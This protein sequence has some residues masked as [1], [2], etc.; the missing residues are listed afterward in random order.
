MTVKF[1]DLFAGIGGIRIGVQQALDEIGVDHECVLSCEIDQK[2]RETYFE[3]FAE[4]PFPDIRELKKLPDHDILLAGFPCQPFSYAGKQQG[5]GDTRG[6]LFFEIE[7]LI[8]T[9]KPKLV[10]LENVR[11]LASHDKGRTLKTILKKLENLGYGVDFRI[12]NSANHG[13]PQN[14]MR[15][16][17]VAILGKS[18][19]ITINSDDKF[20]DTHQFLDAQPSLFDDGG[21]GPTVGDCL[22]SDVDESYRCSPKFTKA[23]KDYCNGDFKK[24]E[25]MRLI[26]SRNGNS[27]HSWELGLR[28]KC[29]KQEIA[30][31]DAIIA[32]RRKKVFG[33]EKDGKELSI[34]QI[35]TFFD[36]PNLADL[37]AGLVKKGYLRKNG[38]LYNP[39]IG[40]FSFEVFKFLNPA[41]VSITLVSSDADRIGVIDSKGPR[42]I[43]PREAARFQGFPEDF[44]INSNDRFAYHQFGN[45]VSVPV[46][47]EVLSNIFLNNKLGI[48]EIDRHKLAAIS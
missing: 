18:P 19:K 7:R 38:N 2:A 32:N 40:N 42:K 35:R 6:T 3:N 46:I 8:A 9:S 5:F 1:V 12:L 41:S 30:L 48:K 24:L 26:D 11:G 36:V 22:E 10:L 4:W 44:K 34:R 29:T 16:Y 15:I 17:I 39:T 28:G 25:G 45:S 37:L 14:R 27:I 47:R 23:L 20:V 21:S 33:T 31:M 13:V 43:T